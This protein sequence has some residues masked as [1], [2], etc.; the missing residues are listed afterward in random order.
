M[1]NIFQLI[2]GLSFIFGLLSCETTEKITVY[3]QPG[4]EIYT[5]NKKK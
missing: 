2:C 4:T 5:P 1:R 3:G